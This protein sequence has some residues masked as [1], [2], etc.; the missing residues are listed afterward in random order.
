MDR[1]VKI[2]LLASG[3]GT[4]VENIYNYFKGNNQIKISCI[5][6]NKP[7]AYVLKRAAGLSIDFLVFNREDFSNSDTIL[8]Y[9][10]S[11][12][13]NFIVLAG[14]L[15]LIP[16]WLTAKFPGRIINI[17]PALLPK[18]GGKGMYGDNVHKAVFENHETETGITVHMVNDKYD[19][20]HIIFQKSVKIDSN[21]TPDSIACKVHELEYKYYPT[22]IEKIAVNLL[23]EF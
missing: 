1:T 21:D 6:C 22:I 2:A 4:N 11:K 16:G 7:D 13:V 23:N 3:S 20:G 5:L 19:E 12:N 10:E 8:T 17:H 14:F 15:W 9:L 18:Y